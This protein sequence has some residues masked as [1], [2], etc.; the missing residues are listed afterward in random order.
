M[1]YKHKLKKDLINRNFFKKSEM[2]NLVF[3]YYLNS[4]LD[5][6]YKKY[7]FYKFVYKF[8][9]NSSSSR[10]VNRC[11]LTGRAGGVVRKFMLSRI[12]FKEFADMGQI[13][14]VRRAV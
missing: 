13:C 2:S 10:I 3:K 7:F 11:L 9:L 6:K 5:H 1:G 14:G 8:H 4:N 12:T